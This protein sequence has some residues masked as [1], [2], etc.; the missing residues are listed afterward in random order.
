VRS[1]EENFALRLQQALARSG[2]TQAAL[3]R[4]ADIDQSS[5][6]RYLRGQCEPNLRQFRSIAQALAIRPSELLPPED[7]DPVQAVAQGEDSHYFIFRQGEL[8]GQW[9]GAL[10]KFGPAIV[11]TGKDAK[12]LLTASAKSKPPA[13]RGRAGARRR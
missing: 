7:A 3:A 12:K 5:I 11:V 13:S 6:S 4:S 2:M 9:R 10:E 8:V 1:E